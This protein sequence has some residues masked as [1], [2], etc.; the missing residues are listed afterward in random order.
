M[1]FLKHLKMKSFFR[2]PKII[3]KPSKLNPHSN[4]NNSAETV[5]PPVK[6]MIWYILFNI[7]FNL[8][9]LTYMILY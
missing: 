6:Q 5:K 9:I 1:V 8:P 7:V 3:Q 4:N 2:L